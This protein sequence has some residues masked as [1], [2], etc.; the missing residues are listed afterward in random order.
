MWL[1]VS[2]LA[3]LAC[4]GDKS[5]SDTGASFLPTDTVT[6][7]DDDT[8]VP[9][10]VEDSVPALPPARTSDYVFLVD[11]TRGTL[12]RI[13]AATRQ[14]RTVA[15]GV[16]PELVATTP[17]E[18]TAV[19]LNRGDDTVA[20]VDVESLTVKT[21]GVRSD[22]DR[23]LISPSGTYAA[24]WNGSA[25][26]ASPSGGLQ[27]YSELSLVR[28]SDG[29]HFPTAVGFGPRS[30]TFFADG[31]GVVIATDDALSRL[32]L[33]MDP[34]EYRRF[35][36][37]PDEVE[38]PVVGEVVL[39][40]SGRFAFVRQLGV[41]RLRVV[42]LETGALG[43]VDVGVDPS[44]LDLDPDGQHLTVVA[45]AGHEL[46]RLATADPYA[47]AEIVALPHDA[48]FGSLVFD[49]TGRY[50]VLYTTAA[51]DPRY[52][53]W[54]LATS[55]VHIRGVVKPIA[56]AAVS[57]DGATLL[58]FHQ[59]ADPV[60]ADPASPFFGQSALSLVD[61]GSLLAN[62]LLLPGPVASWALSDSGKHAYVVLQ[63]QLWFESLDL[64]T[65][66]HEQVA[67]P[68]AP[69]FTGSLPDLDL[70]DGD[71]P[72]AWVSQHHDLGR[73]SFWDADDGSLETITGFELNADVE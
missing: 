51:L 57:P 5:T 23:L 1:G 26:S 12:T 60:N 64:R 17:D 3:L 21:V 13:A 35:E 46:W 29:A 8:T 36:L 55:E 72:P 33:T 24:L 61:L 70:D 40:P 54:D 66:L 9:P 38:P 68:S 16:G 31:S 14:V 56:S 47:P 28:T 52:G 4:G 15:V 50:G 43:Q 53:L 11:P 18:S 41:E 49:P 73:I 27:S 20:L 58:L 48:D 32:D 19:V 30:V 6:G 42:D 65:L 39:A 10:E 71:E 67:L 45:R 69:V 63:D 62:P 59:L 34:P 25:S 22:L 37:A 2:I 44:D 7:D